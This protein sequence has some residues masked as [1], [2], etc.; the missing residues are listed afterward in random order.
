MLA[1][2]F[3]QELTV[4]CFYCRIYR[5]SPNCYRFSTLPELRI[6]VLV[7]YK[8]RQ[9]TLDSGVTQ[10]LAL[11]SFHCRTRPPFAETFMFYGSHELRLSVLV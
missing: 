9:A 4:K 7:Y 10:R 11:T 6:N 2:C 3:T 5:H 8:K 1:S